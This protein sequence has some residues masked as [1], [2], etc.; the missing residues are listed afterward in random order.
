MQSFEDRLTYRF[1][2]ADLLHA[3][4]THRSSTSESAATAHNERLE[5]L[6]DAVLQLVVTEFLYREYP[7]LA[8]GQMAKVRAAVVN[9]T[10]LSGVASNIR[11]GE[12]LRLGRGE[13]A[14]GGREKD[15]ILADAMEAVLAA[16]YLDGGYEAAR[17]VIFHH[18]LDA[19]R[20]R[21]SQPGSRD[22]KTR[23]QESLAAVGKEPVYTATGVGPDHERVFTVVLTVDGSEI[24]RGI[25]RSKKAAEQAAAERALE[26]R[27]Q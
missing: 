25:G 26:S 23:L 8:E 9:R 18:W 3:A 5:F 2:N 11:L 17:S 27:G 24:S 22:F 1:A 20:D 7:G 10:Y 19:V 21:A 16:V 6:G 14:T 15:S 4:F 12:M 13:E